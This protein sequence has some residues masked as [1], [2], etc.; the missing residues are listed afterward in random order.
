MSDTGMILS[1][2][3][4]LRECCR[5]EQISSNRQDE[6][7]ELLENSA[8]N[9]LV[10]NRVIAPSSHVPRGVRHGKTQ[11]TQYDSSGFAH[12]LK[13]DF[14]WDAGHYQGPPF[15]EQESVYYTD[16]V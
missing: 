4:A 13:S 15:S 6:D 8:K 12:Q 11:M 16:T 9:L 7:L 5:T 10:V 14:Q 1:F 2:D 3:S